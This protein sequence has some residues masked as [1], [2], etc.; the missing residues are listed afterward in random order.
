MSQND[1]EVRIGAEISDLE[2]GMGK[3]ASTV[4][5]AAA[6]IGGSLGNV[7]TAMSALSG[8]VAGAMAGIAASLSL[9]AFKRFAD[10]AAAIT[11]ASMDLGR[12][13]GVSATQASIWTAAMAD[14]GA[15]TGELQAASRGLAMRLRAN[16]ESLNAMGLA[17]RTAAG[18]LKSMDQ[19][20]VDAV[21]TV[22]RYKEGTDRNLA[23]QEIFGR[24]VA[25]SSKLLLINSQV[26]AENE[27]YMRRLGSV[28]GEDNVDAWHE[29]D[30]AMDKVSLALNAFKKMIG[31][32][33][34]PVLAKFAEWFSEVAP[35]AI[36]VLRGALGGL[37]TAFWG[38]YN[39]IIIVWETINAMVIS[40]AEPIRALAASMARALVGD[41]AGAKAELANVPRVIGDAW[42]RH[43]ARILE[44]S[45]ETRDK[46]A[47]LFGSQ[48]D[49]MGPKGGGADYISPKNKNDKSASKAPGQKQ[50]DAEWE[51][52]ESA[53]LR[54][55]LYQ[56]AE[57]RA[58]AE[59][60]AFARAT[61]A[62][63]EWQADLERANSA[64]ADDAKRKA[65]QRAQVEEL[66]AQNATS[67]RLAAVDE[68]EA[69]ARHEVEIGRMTKDELLAQEIQFEQQRNEIRLQALQDRLANIDPDRDP[70]AYAEIN[71]AIEE[72]E[73][74]HQAKLSELRRQ[75]SVEHQEIS[76]N[77]YAGIEQAMA[78]SLQ[79]MM[80]LQ[81]S[82]AGF[83]KS[84]WQGVMSAITGEIAKW[85]AQWIMAKLKALI[86][87][88]TTALSEI[89]T[90]AAKAG[91]GGT[92]SMA[93]APWPLN[94]T[95]P[96][97]GAAMSAAAM[98]FAPMA[99]AAMGYDIPAGI[100][101][102][103]QLHAKE[104]VLPEPIA[105]AVRGMAEDGGVGG[106]SVNI[107]AMDSQDVERALKSNGALARA[108]KDL[109][110][111]FYR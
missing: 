99:S 110:R 103:T 44:S 53:H 56:L 83:M 19:I 11:E 4:E 32:S 88:K 13:M 55:T 87:T 29:Y 97:F 107:T 46:I 71:I 111:R 50:T 68:A 106:V 81:T 39:G 90:N 60:A 104:M 27:E 57:E 45:R 31:D 3:G 67:A 100:N 61:K 14:V 63:E 91:A 59:E 8:G 9:A 95:A 86:M 102:L 28:V 10:S 25:G 75:A 98:A 74:E 47:A 79:R 69:Q 15:S 2:R 5:A 21:E 30:S 38:L 41:F 64:V 77:I 80:M 109:D 48:A 35:T 84:L 23:V 108:I 72:L 70:V 54:R 85:L 96:A 34:M 105:N 92:A 76:L 82:F 93:A 20:M 89:T 33:L 58:A 65:E 24:S 66:W 37:L 52:E 78:S 94:M 36:L 62:A 7:G 49:S 17:T 101:P 40:V 26:L 16:E 42:V 43:N 12:A 51:M 18:D 6:R 22:N 73:R 1:I